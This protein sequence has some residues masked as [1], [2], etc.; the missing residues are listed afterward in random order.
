MSR[1]I[2]EWMKMFKKLAVWIKAVVF[3]VIASLLGIG[4]SELPEFSSGSSDEGS[5]E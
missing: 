3:A 2:K 5:R 1:M 4:Y